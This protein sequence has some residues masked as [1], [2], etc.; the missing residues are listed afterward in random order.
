MRHQ[1]SIK[2]PIKPMQIPMNPMTI[3]ALAKVLVLRSEVTKPVITAA[4]DPSPEI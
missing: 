4:I 3:P 1:I 2:T